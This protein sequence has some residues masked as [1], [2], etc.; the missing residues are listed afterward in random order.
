[1]KK[2]SIYTELNFTAL[3]YHPDRNQDKSAKRKF[4]DISAAFEV[5]ND[6]RKRH[7]YDCE[8]TGRSTPY[9]FGHGFHTATNA[10]NLFTQL[11]SDIPPYYP[12]DQ[13]NLYGPGLKHDRRSYQPP[14]PPYSY[15]CQ[16][17][18]SVKRALPVSLEELY[19][20]TTKRLKITRTLSNKTTDK[21]LTVNVKPGLEHG[22]IIYFA[23]EGDSLPTGEIQDIVFEIQQKPHNIFTRKGD[24]LHLTMKISLLEALTG[25]KKSIPRLDKTSDLIVK[26]KSRII[27][28]GQEE[29]II[30][31]GMPNVNTGEKGDMVVHFE[32]EFPQSLSQ[33]QRQ[34]LERI[35]P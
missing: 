11:F 4:Q 15:D 14:S 34:V 16:K 3:K 20:G 1:M 30:G 12:S 21:V 24:N 8:V 10:E 27:Q 23:G 25:F 5:L 31:E 9:S 17:P 7:E 2:K 18:Q 22:A 13:D 19:T 26:N 33:K 32:V 29:I 35:L 6:K 28:S